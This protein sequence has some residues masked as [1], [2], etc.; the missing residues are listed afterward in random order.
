MMPLTVSMANG[1]A[2]GV[3][4]HALLKPLR[5]RIRRTDWLL[6]AISALFVA[7]LRLAA[8]GGRTRVALHR[9]A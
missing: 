6:L 3:T 7:R 2:F 9:A 4:A 5:G 8:G 1:L